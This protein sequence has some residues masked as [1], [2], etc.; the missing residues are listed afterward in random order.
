[1]SLTVPSLTVPKPLPEW[2]NLYASTEHILRCAFGWHSKIT[3]RP[4]LTVSVYDQ[5]YGRTPAKPASGIWVIRDDESHEELFAR[6]LD[7][8]MRYE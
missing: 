7:W 8:V 6:L 1:M 3:P 5:P 4:R 2:W